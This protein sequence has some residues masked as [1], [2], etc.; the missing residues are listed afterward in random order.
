M[1]ASPRPKRIF[2]IRPIHWLLEK[3][4]IVICAGGGG[5]PT[6]YDPDRE[7]TLEGVEVVIDKDFAAALLARDLEADL[8][9][10]ATDADGVYL[11]WGTPQRAVPGPYHHRPNWPS[12][13]FPR[14]HGP[15]LPRHANSSAT[16][17]PAAIG[18][19][20]DIERIVAGK[21]GTLIE[22]DER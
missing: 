16:G 10:M 22:P 12:Y 17:H 14:Q 6:V 11:D 2:E 18:A 5:I 7:R 1:V 19:L 15:R 13:A 20:A 21:A 3:G 9:I 8:Y 4:V